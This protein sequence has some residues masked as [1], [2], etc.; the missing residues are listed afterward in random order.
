MI[1][2]LAHNEIDFEK[3]DACIGQAINGLIYA[4]SW[5][6]NMAAPGWDALVEGDYHAVMP[7]PN[8]RKFGISYVYHPCFVQQ[9]GIFGS[10][11]LSANVTKRFIDAIPRH[12]RNIDYPLNTYNQF[13]S[14]D[15]FT[16]KRGIT[17]HLD[18]IEP[19]EQIAARYSTNTRRNL[20]KAHRHGIYVAHTGRPEEIVGAFRQNRGR[21]LESF[22]A[23]DYERLKHLIYAGIHRGMVSLISAYNDK[24][25]FCAGIVIFRSNRKAVLLFTGNTPEGLQSGAMFALID[26]YIKK[27]S[28]VD[29]VFDFEG[30][31]DLQLARF[32]KGFGSKECVFLQIKFNRL[33]RLVWPFLKAYQSR[34]KVFWKGLF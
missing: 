27:E 9:L 19:Y 24:N 20:A 15:G 30:S 16:V 28:G 13:E 6:L 8:R 7:L 14:F 1:R 23:K 26:D 25:S 12:I 34:R 29:L 17:H 5:Y 31:S 11:N 22:A 32:Y 33:P 4:Y 3:W 21:K 18:L 2:Y 10:G